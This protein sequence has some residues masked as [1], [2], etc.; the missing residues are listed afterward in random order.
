MGFLSIFTSGPSDNIG[1][2]GQL[3]KDAT[4]QKKTGD[5]NGAIATLRTAYA[6]IA[7][8]K[9]EYGV[10]TFLRLPM[11][12]QEAGR[13]DEAWAEFNKMTTGGYPI[14]AINHSEVG[15]MMLGQIYDKMR[16]F[17]QREKRYVEAVRHAVLSEAYFALGYAR[18][19]RGEEYA[20]HTSADTLQKRLG[21]LLKKA[22]RDVT[23][24][25]VTTIRKHFANR[26]TLNPVAVLRD[27]DA[28]LSV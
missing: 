10:E 22:G 5:L 3:L 25:L 24:N 18:Q 4:A 7:K 9:I 14:P 16:L 28:V 20:V 19:K 12:L 13:N 11:Y 27:A 6:E 17:L 2:C 1:R 21:P 15:P 23:K 8:T 26:R